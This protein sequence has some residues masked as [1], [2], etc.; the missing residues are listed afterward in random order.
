MTD[1]TWVQEQL[2]RDPKELIDF[3]DDRAYEELREKGIEARMVTAEKRKTRKGDDMWE[4]RDTVNFRHYLFRDKF[5]PESDF[6]IEWHTDDLLERL[7]T[8][9]QGKTLHFNPPV[10]MFVMKSRTNFSHVICP[11]VD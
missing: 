1:L 5:A 11:V 2:T 3:H 8:M 9:E 7:D 6:F 4:L 10:R